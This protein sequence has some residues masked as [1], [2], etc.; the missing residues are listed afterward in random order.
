VLEKREKKKKKRRKGKRD[1]RKVG[2]E[3]TGESLLA[4]AVLRR[5]PPLPTILTFPLFISMRGEE[6]RKKERVNK[7]KVEMGKNRSG[8]RPPASA[9]QL[10]FH[11]YYPLK[12]KERKGKERGERRKEKT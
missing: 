9:A 4:L 10:S 12:E 2:R 11:L 5:F 7:M 1:G 6:K 3:C 8:A